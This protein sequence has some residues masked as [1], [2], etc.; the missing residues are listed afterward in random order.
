MQDTGDGV[1]RISDEVTVMVMERRGDV[2][3]VLFAF[4]WINQ[5]EMRMKT[6]PFDIPKAA[7]DAGLPPQAFSR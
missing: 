5:E 4:N 3:R 7:S 2:R 6:K 1:A